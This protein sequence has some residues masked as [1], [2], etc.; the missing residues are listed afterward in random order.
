MAASRASPPPPA[1][2]GTTEPRS[3][4]PAPRPS[5]AGSCGRG[6]PERRP[7][8]PRP[9]ARGAAKGSR[10]G[11]RSAARL[12][13]GSGPTAPAR[14][15]PP[16]PPP[17]AGLSA[18]WLRLPRSF[19]SLPPGFR[20]RPGI[21]AG[22]RRV[23]GA[24]GLGARGGEQRPRAARRRNGLRGPGGQHPFLV[25]PAP[26]SG[27]LV[28]ALDPSRHRGLGSLGFFLNISVS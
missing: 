20:H 13:G 5:P 26:P 22:K 3:A 6:L 4:Q 19:S 16:P 7:A 9:R 8:R 15:L 21:S 10:L 28:L 18:L 2:G 23:G 25:L 12:G 27:N 17:P 11:A 1:P 24:A 14:P